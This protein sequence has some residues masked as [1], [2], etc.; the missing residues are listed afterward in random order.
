MWVIINGYVHN[1]SRVAQSLDPASNA[2]TVR[3]VPP[4]SGEK[5]LRDL[6]LIEILLTSRIHIAFYQSYNPIEYISTWSL[7]P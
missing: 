4:R 5:L 3:R 1:N 6:K 2:G 7:S